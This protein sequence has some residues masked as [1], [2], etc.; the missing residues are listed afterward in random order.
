MAGPQGARAGVFAAIL[1]KGGISGPD[2]VF[3]GELGLWNQA[4]GGDRF[5]VD[6]PTVFK[7]NVFAIEETTIKTCPIRTGIH[8]P[9]YVA[10][11][12]R[13]KIDVKD[14]VALKAELVRKTS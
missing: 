13:E 12:L 4:F 5:P 7:D 11:K 1:A 8:I 6:P 2:G 14:I 9:V 3:E 10:Q